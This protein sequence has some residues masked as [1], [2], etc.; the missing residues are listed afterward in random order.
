MFGNDGTTM[1]AFRICERI[2]QTDRL[3][4]VERGP[5]ST[6]AAIQGPAYDILAYVEDRGTVLAAEN[7]QGERRRGLQKGCQIDNGDIQEGPY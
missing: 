7:V 3:Q 4:A 5:E 2:R 1:V 6:R